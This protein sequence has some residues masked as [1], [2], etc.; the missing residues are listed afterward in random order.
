MIGDNTSYNAIIHKGW[1]KNLTLVFL[2]FSI[3]TSINFL[4]LSYEE[5]NTRFYAIDDI[6]DEKITYQSSYDP[7]TNGRYF[8]CFSTID[9]C[10]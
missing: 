6:P 1:N 8:K 4:Y 7:K 9:F 2:Q 5:N 3:K 10:V